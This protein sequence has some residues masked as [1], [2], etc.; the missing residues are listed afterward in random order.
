MS[1]NEVM[2]HRVRG[3]GEPA[4]QERLDPHLRPSATLHSHG[5]GWEIRD[6]AETVA[7][8]EASEVRISM[9]WKAY[10]FRDEAHLASFENPAFNLDADQVVDIFLDDLHARG[11]SVERSADPFGDA[12]WRNLL[13]STY[14]SPF[15]SAKS[16]YY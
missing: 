4:H 16:P 10:V 11:L 3:I 1:D 14:I 13:Q 12:D 2:W 5:D 15:G 9:L 6:G 7:S 8:L